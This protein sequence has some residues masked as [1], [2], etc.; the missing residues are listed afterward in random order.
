[1][2]H[3]NLMDKIYRYQRY[4][5]DATRKYYLLGRDQLIAEM[6][7]QNGDQ[8]LEMGCGTA[9]NLIL[10]GKRFPTITLYGLDAS[11]EMLNTAQPKLRS[12]FPG[13]DVQLR[14]CLAEDLHYQAT[15]GLA[16]PFDAIFFSYALSMIPSWEQAMETALGNLKPGGKLYIVDFCD[17]QDL[18]RWF[19][20]LLTVWLSWFHVQHRPELL[21]YLE[22]IHQ[23]GRV[24]VKIEFIRG[25]YA[26]IAHLTK[27][28]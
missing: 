26:F 12:A 18:P 7:L 10:L 17:Q 9:R 6:E 20:K 4:I 1:M 13:R 16:Q 2:E 25:R 22:R 23:E 14:Q 15:F 11:Q 28:S 8:V 24:E 5:Y 21:A 3:A 27:Q 19:R